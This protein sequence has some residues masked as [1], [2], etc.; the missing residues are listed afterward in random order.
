MIC[1]LIAILLLKAVAIYDKTYKYHTDRQILPFHI[2]ILWVFIFLNFHIF[3][4]NPSDFFITEKQWKIASLHRSTY[5]DRFLQHILLD[6][7]E[8]LN[9]GVVHKP[10]TVDSLRLMHIQTNQ[11][12]HSFDRIGLSKQDTLFLMKY[13]I[14][15]TCSLFVFNY[16]SSITWNI[17]EISRKLKI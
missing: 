17:F 6:F 10:I 2:S 13:S 8:H 12:G 15:R 5:L 9:I 11:I 3:L 1:I 7:V 16:N 4:K 14:R